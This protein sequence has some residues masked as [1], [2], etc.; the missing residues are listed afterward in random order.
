MKSQASKLAEY[1]E[2]RLGD[3][4][5]VVGFYSDNDLEMTY[6]RDDLVDKYSNDM[7]ET[8]IDNSQK[9]QKDLQLLDSGMG[10]PEASLHAMED[11]LI[12]QFHISIEDVIF[13]SMEREVGRNFTQFIDE[14]RKQ[15]S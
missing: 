9:I 11:G 2:R 10:E 14:C 15:M 6:I 12:I 4:L 5:R 1:C 3:S 7:V 13:F 8:F